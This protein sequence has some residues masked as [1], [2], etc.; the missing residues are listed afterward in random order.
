M[1]HLVV[2][3]TLLE[4]GPYPFV[5]WWTSTVLQQGDKG[6][7]KLCEHQTLSYHVT[8]IIGSFYLLPGF[9]G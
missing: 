8:H 5:P 9:H 3:G 6:L 2:K 1:G 4:G 7:E